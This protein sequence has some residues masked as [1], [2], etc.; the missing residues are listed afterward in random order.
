MRRTHSKIAG[1]TLLEVLIAI[2]I[3]AVIGLGAYRMLDMIIL[4]QTRVESHTDTLRKTE[5]AMQLISMD[6][7]QLVDRPVRDNYENKLAAVLSPQ[8]N[9]L[10]EFTRQGWRNP[11][12]LPR[13]QLQ[14]VAYELGSLSNND[15]SA[16][17]SNDTGTH[18]LRHYWNVLDRAQDS[19]PRTQVL[20][21]NVDDLQIRFLGSEGNWHSEWPATLASGKKT[22]GLPTAVVFEIH[23]PVLGQ[24]QRLFQLSEIGAW[25]D[26]GVQGEAAS[27]N[28]E[29]T[30]NH[31]EDAD[32]DDSSGVYDTDDDDY[33]DYESD[34]YD[35]Y[36]SDDYDDDDL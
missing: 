2:S 28:S 36:E 31:S 19:E 15:R 17:A 16:S 25:A 26:A 9:Y 23:T 34:D 10:I 12:Q 35:D 22:L 20:L 7:E 33:N 13:S 21:K 4:S 29:D 30:P 1:F 18:L 27:P 24:I 5:R 6:F 14:R 32:E 8:Q 11:L 3:F